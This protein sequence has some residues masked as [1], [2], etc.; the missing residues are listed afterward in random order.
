M[1]QACGRMLRLRP[2]LS[3]LTEA[4][5]AIALRRPRDDELLVNIL[6]EYVRDER[7]TERLAFLRY[8]FGYEASSL[9]DM[10][11]GLDRLAQQTQEY[12]G[13][14]AED[15]AMRLTQF[16]YEVASGS[17]EV[18]SLVLS[19][20]KGAENGIRN[21]RGLGFGRF[22]RL[23]RFRYCQHCTN[24]DKS[25]GIRPY[26]RRAHQLPGVAICH[27]HSSPLLISPV[28]AR[29]PFEYD[30]GFDGFCQ[31]GEPIVLH[32][33]SDDM[34]LRY[35]L[36]AQQSEKV[37]HSVGP[38]DLFCRQA[39]YRE[40]LAAAGYSIKAD[41][42][43]L[44]D[45]S[46]DMVSFFGTSY[47]SWIGL[48]REGQR[49]RDW[50]VPL[51]CDG[52][53]VPPTVAHVLLTVY[54]ES[55]TRNSR[56]VPYNFDIRCPSKFC[57]LRDTRFAGKVTF[58]ASSSKGRAKCD[59]GTA[60]TFERGTTGLYECRI[61]RFGDAYKENAMRLLANG[62]SASDIAK[63]LDVSHMTVRRLT[64]I[65]G[66]NG[67][68][69]TIEI[70][71][72]REEWSSVVTAANGKSLSEARKAARPVYRMLLKYD[73][74]WLAS[75]NGTS[76][77][78]TATRIDWVQRDIAYSSAMEAAADRL[79]ASTPPRWVSKISILMVA[80]VPQGTRNV[81]HRLP[82]CTGLLDRRVE[83]RQSFQ[84][85]LRAWQLGELKEGFE[86]STVG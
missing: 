29:N 54:L 60:F 20:M 26:C 75:F 27:G 6:A 9:F 66:C 48:Y 63:V 81:L 86:S 67:S 50:L 8:V 21:R 4:E 24:E 56:V 45:L 78:A 46:R 19:A 3:N 12:W 57:S 37:L 13:L 38:S 15:I 71:R 25:S 49:T 34:T 82:R 10:P 39:S 35:M 28:P 52:Q 23:A 70:D 36:V 74:D 14:T 83:S 58:D 16:P 62:N 85:R 30:G 55:G 41:F 59:C 68:A 17:P 64:S 84:E 65:S 22:V 80:D 61:S 31:E 33:A 42:V 77:S 1:S 40:R 18:A 44:D 43:R 7:L 51:L 69:S 5:M 72:W 73:R 2:F 79:M 76:R 11:G 53:A 47:L 32:W